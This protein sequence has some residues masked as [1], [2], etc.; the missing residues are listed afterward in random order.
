[1]INMMPYLSLS[2]SFIN[3]VQVKIELK[4]NHCLDGVFSEGYNVGL[5][6]K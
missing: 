5:H 4:I 6:V 1:M 2:L 3:M